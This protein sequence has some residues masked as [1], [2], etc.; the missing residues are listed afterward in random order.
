[1]TFFVKL[2]FPANAPAS[3]KRFMNWIARGLISAIR[4]YR[5]AVARK[6]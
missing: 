2:V 4:F 6:E 1:M 5:A 3:Y